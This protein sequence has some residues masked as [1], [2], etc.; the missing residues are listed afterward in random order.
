[1]LSA[2]AELPP[3]HWLACPF[4]ALHDYFFSQQSSITSD[5]V[6][7]AARRLLALRQG[8]DLAAYDRCMRWGM[9]AGMIERDQALGKELN[10]T[11]TPTLFINGR[12][13]VGMRNSEALRAAIAAAESGPGAKAKVASR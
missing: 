4:W 6:A 3:W 12:R 13:Y 10:I 2:T 8:F 5:T 9:S 1:M 11:G 7:A